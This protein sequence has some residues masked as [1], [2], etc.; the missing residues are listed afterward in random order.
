MNV[1]Q[2]TEENE[3]LQLIHRNVFDRVRK[4]KEQQRI[5]KHTWFY[6]CWLV[7]CSADT[8]SLQLKSIN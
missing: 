5:V 1:N 4:K 8:K 7:Q 6:I 3:L 2:I